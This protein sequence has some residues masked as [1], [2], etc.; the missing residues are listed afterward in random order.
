MTSRAFFFANHQVS[1][2]YPTVRLQYSTHFL[3]SQ[4]RLIPSKM[5][6]GKTRNNKIEFSVKVG[7]RKEI[8]KLG[9]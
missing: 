4:L 5:M 7:Q 2:A 8:A 9:L 6:Q 3:E 1:D